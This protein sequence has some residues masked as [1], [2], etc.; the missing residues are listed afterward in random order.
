M[1][2]FISPLLIWVLAHVVEAFLFLRYYSLLPL[3]ALFGARPSITPKWAG[4]LIYLQPSTLEYMRDV[5]IDDYRARAKLGYAFPLDRLGGAGL[6][7]M[8]LQLDIVHSG[9]RSKPSGTL[10]TRWNLAPW[11]GPMDCSSSSF[12][13]VSR[14][15]IGYK[16]DF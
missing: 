7:L 6:A 4:E 10:S 11:A 12:R 2:K 15:G 13:G 1:F 16:E 8:P 9:Q 3:F 5:V 14:A